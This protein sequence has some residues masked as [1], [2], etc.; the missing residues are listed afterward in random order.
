MRQLR[1]V[2]LL[3]LTFLVFFPAS[4]MT[5]SI[6]VSWNENQESDLQGYKVYCGTQSHQ[7]GVP[8]DVGDTTSYQIDG[9]DNGD[10]Y[11]VAVTAYDTSGN[12]SDY[13]DEASVY[14]PIPDTTPPTGSV[15]INSGDSTTPSRVV[16]LT[17]SAADSNGSVATMRFSNDGL[18]FS[19][20]V[21]YA[22]SQQWVLSEGDG[23][24][25]V[26][27]LFC[28]AAGNWMNTP[29]S[30]S[31][32]L[33]LDTDGDGL[34]DAWETLNSLDPANPGDAGGDSDSDGISNLEEYY[35]N[36]DPMDPSDNLPVVQLL[37]NLP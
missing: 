3:I 35:N 26:Y 1:N 22:T 16:T 30:D 25:T 27:V 33:R 18:N 2:V 17:L 24:K 8:A 6:L 29:V 36:T 11:Y 20:A 32:A 12:E 31:I 5:A 34:P 23:T 13:S 28:D 9:L 15:V 7:Y 14:I 21:A 37:R 4:A 19:D 10:T